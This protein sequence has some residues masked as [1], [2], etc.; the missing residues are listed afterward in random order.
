MRFADRSQSGPGLQDLELGLVEIQDGDVEHVA[1]W[2][3][4]DGRGVLSF[5]KEGV[6]YTV[7]DH[8]GR[9]VWIAKKGTDDRVAMSGNADHQ[10]SA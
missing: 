4:G 3:T 7:G 10:V 6:A 9:A 2:K 8:D 5:G 1:L